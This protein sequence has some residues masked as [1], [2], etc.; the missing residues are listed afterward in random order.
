MSD[1]HQTLND[2]DE[3]TD[4]S[5]VETGAVRTG[6]VHTGAVH[7]GAVQTE[8]PQRSSRRFLL[9]V[10]SIVLVLIF[11]LTGIKSWRDLHER[12]LEARRL[13][14]EISAAE[15]R[16]AVLE[17]EIDRLENDPLTLERL[18]REELGMVRADEVVIILPPSGPDEHTRP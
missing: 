7:A 9:T 13:V 6:A 12:D 15:E 2:H 8:P 10:S 5:A 14:A 16:V 17:A 11:A 3:H 4:T 18:A 1:P